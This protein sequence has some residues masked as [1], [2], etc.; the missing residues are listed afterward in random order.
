MHDFEV[1]HFTRGIL[2]CVACWRYRTRKYRRNRYITIDIL[3]KNYED[4]SKQIRYS[5]NKI[6]ILL[7]I[8]YFVKRI[9]LILYT[10]YFPL[11]RI[12]ETRQEAYG[13]QRKGPPL[14]YTPRQHEWSINP[15][16]YLPRAVNG[17]TYFNGEFKGWYAGMA[18]MLD[19]MLH[20]D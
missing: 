13:S 3:A 20:F 19:H 8:D 16:K 4:Y 15:A 11:L 6:S 12:L 1:I 14:S 17:V 18:S 10:I 5:A 7:I 9:Y 2:K